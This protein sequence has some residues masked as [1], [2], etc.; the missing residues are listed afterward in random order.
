MSQRSTCPI[1]SS[2]SLPHL[3]DIRN[4]QILTSSH[5]KIQLFVFLFRCSVFLR[6]FSRCTWAVV[7]VGERTPTMLWSRTS[8]A[9]SAIRWWCR[10]RSCQRRS[11]L[12]TV[13]SKILH[14][15]SRW[16]IEWCAAQRNLYSKPVIPMTMER[17]I[18]SPRQQWCRTT[19]PMVGRPFI[20]NRPRAAEDPAVSKKLGRRFATANVGS[21]K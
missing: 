14:R 15:L 8:R 7:V 5:S 4:C 17:C 1:S 16:W 3:L 9:C 20:K 11:V 18:R 6:I 19:E 2:F 10:F 12:R 13:C 21:T